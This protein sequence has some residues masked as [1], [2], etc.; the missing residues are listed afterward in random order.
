MVEEIKGSV[1]CKDE[2]GYEGAFDYEV[3]ETTVAVVCEDVEIRQ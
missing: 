1:G 2:N 3:E